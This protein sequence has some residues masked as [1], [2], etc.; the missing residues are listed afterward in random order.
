MPHY[1]RFKG[2]SNPMDFSNLIALGRITKPQGLRGAFR[3]SA[4]GIESEN[5]PKLKVVYLQN[6]DKTF[7]EHRIK[8][9]RKKGNLFIIE[10]VALSNIDQVLPLVNHEVF[11]D[12][13]TFQPLDD[14]E[15]YWYELVGLTVLTKDGQTLG[16]VVSIIPTGSNDVLQV[17]D[18]NSGKEALIPYIDD[19][20]LSVD[21]PKGEMVIDPL[22]GLLDD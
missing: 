6:P 12:P 4:F 14:D 7:V 10:F 5:L 3:L 9:V 1:R 16:T 17:R 8:S 13:E 18:D 19:V 2:T 11:A 20:V 15:F 22:P 21:I